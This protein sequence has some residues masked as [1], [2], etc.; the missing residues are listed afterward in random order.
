MQISMVMFTFSV[1]DGKY[2]CWVN[3]VQKI[4]IFSLNQN[5]IL[6]LIR[7]CRIQCRCAFFLFL[8]GNVLFG[9]KFGP[10]NQNFQFEPKF[11]T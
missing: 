1:F 5:L 6:R 4:K 10:K 3:L 9:D 11:D 8:T 2:L 7:I